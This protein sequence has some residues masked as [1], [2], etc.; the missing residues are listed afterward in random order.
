MAAESCH[1]L[2][3]ELWCFGLSG[4]ELLPRIQNIPV[5]VYTSLTVISPE[6][7]QSIL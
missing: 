5:I 4:E 6:L 7:P 3:L 2:A 1:P